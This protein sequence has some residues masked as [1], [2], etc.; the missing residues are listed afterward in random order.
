VIDS[1][2]YYFLLLRCTVAYVCV[3]LISAIIRLHHMH[4]MQSI[5]TDVHG[6]C[7][8]VCHAAYLGFT[9]QKMAE[10]IKMLFGVNTPGGP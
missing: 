3:C 9:V 1:F 2:L 5:L 8:S 6:I 4:E 7:Q 10:Q